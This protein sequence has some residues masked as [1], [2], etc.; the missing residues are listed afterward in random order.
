M[1]PG[2]A[3]SSSSF[4]TRSGSTVDDDFGKLTREELIAEIHRLRRG[5][6]T[7]EKTATPESEEN[8]S[9]VPI[10][11]VGE[12]VLLIDE[13]LVVVAASANAARIFGY[14]ENEIVGYPA[15]NL[16]W[17]TDFRERGLEKAWAMANRV[18]SIPIER[19]FVRSDGS[20]IW[21]RGT[22]VRFERAGSVRVV[23]SLR[24][25]SGR[26]GT[27]EEQDR[28][29][30]DANRERA[31]AEAASRMKDEFIARV[32]HEL[33]NPLAAIALWLRLVNTNGPEASSAIPA[34]E[35][36]LS[37]ATRIVDDLLDVSR[38]LQG[39]LRM[40]VE[41]VD[42][43]LAMDTTIESL[44]PT[45]EEKGVTMELH[46][47]DALWTV[48]DVGRLQQAF[49]NVLSNA[50]K[51]ST[52]GGR[53]VTAISRRGD[54]ALV[55]VRDEGQ[56]IAPAFLAR[57]F[58]PFAQARQDDTSGLGLGL[59]IVRQILELHGGSAR[60][61]SP[62]LGL[63][64]TFTLRLPIRDASAANERTP[65]ESSSLLPTPIRILVIED[66]AS[67]REGMA[68]FLRNESIDVVSAA[69]AAEGWKCVERERPDAI[70]CDLAMPDEDG[71]S[72]I[73]RL[74]QSEKGLATVPIPA[75]AITANAMPSRSAAA[76]AAGFQQ[77][78]VKPIDTNVLLE[79]IV[80]L[81][82][83]AAC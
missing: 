68:A 30:S 8:P 15:A 10:D 43:V 53:V 73:R 14:A 27:L 20:R 29:L 71:L 82:R 59:T 17:S 58:V 61:E 70:L 62:G 26:R 11:A 5:G 24:D 18:G 72:F 42:L 51:F 45:A 32:S 75:A 1:R 67:L 40:R 13:H 22:M 48:G 76:L 77:C 64:A 41:P 38:G 56:G 16:L 57:M 33:R 49:S 81:A 35:R 80:R 34:I 19:W 78:L 4:E 69:T 3:G 44:L 50:I 55:R 12:A 83:E 23:L 65:F 39:K 7:V 6:S 36:A 47:P 2:I 60:G 21:L 52:R 66:D 28:R 9:F 46:A 25:E 37:A 54:E 31:E 74:R 63:G 79:T